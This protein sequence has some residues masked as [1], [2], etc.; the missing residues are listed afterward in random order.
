MLKSKNNIFLF[1][2]LFFIST[3]LLSAF[4]IQYSLEQQP[5]TLCLYQR[6][7]YA[8][9]IFLIAQLLI[10]K[11]YEQVTLLIISLIF[12]VSAALAFY[13]FGIE[14]GFFSESFVCESK[15]ISDSLSKEKLLE[16]LKQK[17]ISCK[18]ISFKILGL[19]LASINII[20]STILSIIFTKRF[21]NYGK[22]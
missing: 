10:F 6:I 11:K 5:C 14:Q 8:F 3:V 9:A 21:I 13:H 18:D 12:I 15:N 7:P 16:Q 2:V 20:F 19:S 22:N 1:L 17:P 4:I